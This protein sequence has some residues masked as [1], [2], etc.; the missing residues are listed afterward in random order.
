MYELDDDNPKHSKAIAELTDAP[1][2]WARAR[3]AEE[4]AQWHYNKEILREPMGRNYLNHYDD[5]DE[6]EWLGID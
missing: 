1:A 4:K 5:D 2:D 3:Q 6:K